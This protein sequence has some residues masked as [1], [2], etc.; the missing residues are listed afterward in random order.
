[1]NE[2]LV[3]T[4]IDL[5]AEI[6]YV[7]IYDIGAGIKINIPYVQGNVGPGKDTVPVSQKIFEELEFLCSKC[8]GFVLTGYF[9]TVKVHYEVS[10]LENLTTCHWLLHTFKQGTNT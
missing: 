8:D 6:I 9:F 5:F 2:R 4:L 3:K 7:N 10:S 1:M